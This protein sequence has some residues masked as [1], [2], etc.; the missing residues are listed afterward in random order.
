MWLTGLP[1]VI[2]LVHYLGAFSTFCGVGFALSIL[3][4]Q[5]IDMRVSLS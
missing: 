3:P 5:F 1:K 2:V 4:G